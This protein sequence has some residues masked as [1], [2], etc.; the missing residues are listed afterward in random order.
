MCLLEGKKCLTFATTKSSCVIILMELYHEL[1]IKINFD[2]LS[3]IIKGIYVMNLDTKPTADFK[4][5]MLFRCT[6]RNYAEKF[7]KTGN[8]RFG[9]PSE[10]IDYYK[11]NGDGRGDLLEGSFASSDIYDDNLVN[12]FKSLRTNVTFIKD[13]RTGH[14]YFQSQD[15]LKLRTFCVF[16]LNTS[17]FPKSL[18]GEDKNIYPTGNISKQYFE[19]FWDKTKEETEQLPDEQKPVL[20]IIK[21]PHEFFERLRQSL[22]KLGFKKN[23]F[24]IQPVFYMDKHQ[25]FLVN[26][27]MPHE[28]FFKDNKFNYQSE[29]RVVL[30]PHNPDLIKQLNDKNGILDIGCMQDIAEVQKYYF[31]DFHMQ[32]RGNKLLFTLPE[33]IVTPIT[34]PKEV[35]RYIYQVY[36]DELPGTLNAEKREKLIDEAAKL[37]KNK[38]DIPFY[39]DSL[40]F[41]IDGK[42]MSFIPQEIAKVLFRHGYNYFLQEKYEQSIDQYNKAL[43]MDPQYAAAWYNRAVCYHRL[44][45]YENMF[46]DMEKA[47][48]LDP[49]NQKYIR[50]RNE[51]IRLHGNGLTEI[52]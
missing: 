2:E 13:E 23:D 27:P 25:Q 22:Y 12:T 18:E 19:D 50:E 24:I 30:T 11:K 52:K 5:I 26:A 44:G 41:V 38:F 36:C 39:K 37:L 43:E 40:S 20:L 16:G 45:K 35:I 10:W 46:S 14:F 17:L 28:L 51:Q 32:L 4:T 15:V 31:S 1:V 6:T 49:E 9:N 47:I 34:D 42:I 33:P 29:I 21:N 8:I 3:R 48:S 7:I